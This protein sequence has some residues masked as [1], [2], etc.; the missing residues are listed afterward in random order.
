MCCSDRLNSPPTAAIPA[1]SVFGNDRVRRCPFPGEDRKSPVLCESDAIDLSET[2]NPRLSPVGCHFPLA[3][4][5]QSA[6]LSHAQSVA[7]RLWGRLNA[8]TRVHHAYRRCSGS[9]AD[10]GA[11]SAVGGAGG[12]FS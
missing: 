2:S 4:W 6:S 1:G 11:R 7:L 3:D 10:R 12:W 8:A 9:L 5:S